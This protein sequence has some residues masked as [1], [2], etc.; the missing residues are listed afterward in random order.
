[1][2]SFGD[3]SKLYQRRAKQTLPLLVA[4]AKACRTFTYGQLAR[5]MNMPNPRNLNHVLGAVGHELEALSH[6]WNEPIPPIECIVLNKADKTPGRGIGFHMPVEKFKRLAPLA[7]K[8][9]VRNLLSEIWGFTKWDLVL[10]HFHLKAA[11]PSPLLEELITEAAKYGRAGGESEEHRLLKEYVAKNPHALGLPKKA[12]LI[13]HC[14]SSADQIDVL[15]KYDEEWVGVEVKGIHSADSDI[16]RGVFQC[17]KYQ[18]ILEAEQKL[19]GQ[20]VNCRV[21]LV[22]GGKLPEILR[23]VVELLEIDVREHVKIPEA[24]STIKAK[25]AAGGR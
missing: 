9:I 3:G 1:M 14:L 15:F 10:Q 2:K 25:K 6:K 23:S 20:T 7:K 4:R 16:F 12:P 24:V 5:L 8:Q 18:A 17:V 19:R 11:A 13:E 21:L 22:L